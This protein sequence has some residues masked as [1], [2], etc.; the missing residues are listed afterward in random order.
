MARALILLAL[1][2]GAACAPRTATFDGAETGAVT[3]NVRVATLRVV[4]PAS[5]RP[6]LELRT[7]DGRIYA[8]ALESADGPAGIG[9]PSPLGA[10][11]PR[12]RLTGQL[13]AEGQAPMACRFDVLNPWRGLD[14]GGVGL[15]QAPPQ[16]PLAG[17]RIDFVF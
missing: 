14:G 10:P 2:A 13:L 7:S 12:A 5:S 3:D 16:G 15:C 8:G 9:G 6:D 1:L 17:R 11:T 4:G